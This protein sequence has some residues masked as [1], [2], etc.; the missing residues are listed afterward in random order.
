MKNEEG[1]SYEGMNNEIPK[2]YAITSENRYKLQAKTAARKLGGCLHTKQ[3]DAEEKIAEAENG[4]MYWGWKG[5]VAQWR[6]S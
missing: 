6:M 5:R 1:Y 4:N 3:C 2:M